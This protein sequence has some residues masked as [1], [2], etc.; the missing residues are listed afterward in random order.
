MRSWL[1][2]LPMVVALIL[3]GCAPT[4]A[5]PAAPPVAPGQPAA[6]AA[7]PPSIQRTLVIIGGR[8][9]DSLSSKPLRDERGAGRPRATM[10][11][12]NAGLVLNDERDLPRPYLAEAVP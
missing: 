8:A 9:P 4:P 1:Q 2:T 10:R 6:P 7:A 12:F 5:T 11:A 3:V